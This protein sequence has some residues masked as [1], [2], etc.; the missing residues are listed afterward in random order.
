MFNQEKETKEN[1]E[2]KPKKWGKL[3]FVVEK[4][5]CLDTASILILPIIFFIYNIYYWFFE[6]HK[7]DY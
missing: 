4:P 2:I 7:A 1:I 6:E 5:R 3:V